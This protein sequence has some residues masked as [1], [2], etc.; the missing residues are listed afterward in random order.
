M[1][2]KGG[3]VKHFNKHPENEFYTVKVEDA[4]GKEKVFSHLGKTALGEYVDVKGGEKG[5]A[6]I[7]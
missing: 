5:F 4:D 2:I 3:K 1:M 6:I 7:F